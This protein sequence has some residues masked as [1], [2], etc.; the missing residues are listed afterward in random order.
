MNRAYSSTVIRTALVA[1]AI[2]SESFPNES[3]ALKKVSSLKATCF[4]HDQFRL[5]LNNQDYKL[6]I[7]YSYAIVTMIGLLLFL[8]FNNSFR[9]SVMNISIIQRRLFNDDFVLES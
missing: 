7:L 6:I 9:R 5:S 8:M 4:Q 2:P 1:C 3:C